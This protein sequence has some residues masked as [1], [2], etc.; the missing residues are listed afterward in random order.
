M[1]LYVD[2]TL[3]GISR[4]MDLQRL[5]VRVLS[6]SWSWRHTYEWRCLLP[7]HHVGWIRCAVRIP[8]VIPSFLWV[9]RCHCLLIK[10]WSSAGSCC[11]SSCELPGL[12]QQL[13]SFSYLDMPIESWWFLVYFCYMI[14]I[15]YIF[16]KIVYIDCLEILL[17]IMSVYGFLSSKCMRFCFTH[18]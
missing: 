14:D 17:H 2:L 13:I 4:G 10:C 3:V 7:L 15:M 5:N 12:L 11:A 16:S 1:P 8:S 6:L 18:L 9:A